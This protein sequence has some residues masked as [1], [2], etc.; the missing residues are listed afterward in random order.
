LVELRSEPEITHGGVGALAEL[1]IARHHSPLSSRREPV[2]I[3]ATVA[4]AQ[5]ADRSPDAMVEQYTAILDVSSDLV[6]ASV[7]ALAAN[8]ALPAVFF[9]A[10]G[11]DRTGVLSAV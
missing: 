5:S 8:D 1:V 4:T 9:C 6:V 11:K 10:A 2:A 7:E 3:D